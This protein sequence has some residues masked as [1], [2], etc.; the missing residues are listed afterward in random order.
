MLL[1]VIS[2]A[3]HDIGPTVSLAQVQATRRYSQSAPSPAKPKPVP[4]ANSRVSAYMQLKVN[5]E[6]SLERISKGASIKPE[7]AMT[8]NKNRLVINKQPS[9]RLNWQP[10]YVASKLQNDSDSEDED[11]VSSRSVKQKPTNG[12]CSVS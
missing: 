9:A 8:G 7:E 10:S 3:L 6:N 1:L 11:E 2:R 12:W 5:I 4:G